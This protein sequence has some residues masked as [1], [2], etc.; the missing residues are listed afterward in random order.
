MADAPIQGCDFEALRSRSMIDD[1][2]SSYRSRFP[3]V[4]F[5]VIDLRK[6]TL[7]PVGRWSQGLETQSQQTGDPRGYTLI[8][9]G[10]ESLLTD[11]HDRFDRFRVTMYDH[12]LM[13]QHHSQFVHEYLVADSVLSADFVINVPKLKTHVKAGI[14]G[15]LKNLVGINGHKEYLPHH[16][17]GDPETGGDQYR[18]RSRIKPLINRLNDRYWRGHTRRGRIHNIVQASVI[19]ACT[20]CLGEAPKD[21]PRTYDCRTTVQ[22]DRR[23]GLNRRPARHVLRPSHPAASSSFVSEHNQD[24]YASGLLSNGETQQVRSYRTSPF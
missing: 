23:D 9:L 13:H 3:D 24:Y 15:A 4:N 6:T 10:Q 18:H 20:C 8:D 16:V 1:L 17:N 2:L 7:T 12:R 21:H 19:R 22:A 14:T 5:G 11:I